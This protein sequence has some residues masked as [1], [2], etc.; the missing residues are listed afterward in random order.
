MSGWPVHFCLRRVILQMA[1]SL[2]PGSLQAPRLPVLAELRGRQCLVAVHLHCSS[3]ERDCT[4]LHFRYLFE[5]LTRDAKWE[6]LRHVQLLSFGHASQRLQRRLEL[7]GLAHWFLL[8]VL[9]YSPE[10]GHIG[11]EKHYL[12]AVDW[13][14]RICW[15]SHSKRVVVCSQLDSVSQV[16]E[17]SSDNV[18]LGHPWVELEISWVNFAMLEKSSY[19]RVRKLSFLKRKDS[20][21]QRYSWH[22]ENKTT[23]IHVQPS[24]FN[25][26]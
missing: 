11:T 10:K 12:I 24:R 23:S 16:S 5:I 3:L 9:L 1:P 4:I 13:S 7:Q 17:G 6:F 15:D 8:E 21:M 19:H 18:C 2:H 26:C 22:S 20:R 25:K 14:G